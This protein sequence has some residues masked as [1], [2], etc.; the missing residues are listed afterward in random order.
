MKTI[1]I[2]LLVLASFIVLTAT[3]QYFFCPVYSFAKAVPFN[4]DSIY[5]PYAA[6]IQSGWVK[7]NFHAH[8]HCW[9]GITYGHGTPI[10]IH[11]VYNNLHY[12]VHAVSNYQSID[13]ASQSSPGYIG[14][15][16]HGYN[17]LKS[18]QLVIGANK[19]CFKGN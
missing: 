19:V 4:G 13:T 12:G 8:A 14:C 15:Y 6:S 9:D 18:H 1:L 11:H 3:D 2:V 10:D 5:N 7:C 16:E 17:M